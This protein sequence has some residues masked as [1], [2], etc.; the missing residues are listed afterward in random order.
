[1]QKVFRYLIYSPFVPQFFVSNNKYYYIKL[2]EVI[3]NRNKLYL[4]IL[5]TSLIYSTLGYSAY[6]GSN[7]C[8]AMNEAEITADDL[9]QAAGHYKHE[10]EH[11]NDM[12]AQEYK[13][14]LAS[15]TLGNKE[16]MLWVGEIAQGEHISGLTGK[17]AVEK[18]I[19]YWQLAAEN[20]Q[21][22]GL[23]DI[24]LLYLHQE[25]PGGGKNFA[26]IEQ[27]YEQA[28]SYLNR[29]TEQGD[30]KA[31][32]YLGFLYLEGKGSIGKDTYKATEYFKKAAEL[33]DSTG[34]L[35]YANALISGVG[36]QQNISDAI[37]IYD[38]VVKN[39]EHDAVEC[40]NKLAGIYA[41]DQYNLKN[42][43][44]SNN[45]KQIAI[46]LATNH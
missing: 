18:A 14:A 19:E 17:A 10:S 24:G 23:T 2:F 27:D 41:S 46:K 33:G 40:A 25:I 45:Y 37:K 29:A 15:A 32:R 39:N 5:I 21:P 42:I 7:V 3:M 26:G 44:K 30:F 12:Y 31:P 8:V 9:L 11:G 43:E 28:I 6:I 13:F 36:I 35:Y 20:G 22:R 34:K 38:S 1:M 16:A 4:P